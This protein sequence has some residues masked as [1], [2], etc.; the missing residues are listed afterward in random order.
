M[1]ISRDLL[2]GESDTGSNASGTRTRSRKRG[3]P[4]GANASPAK[5]TEL[6]SRQTRLAANSR[7][8][9]MEKVII[10]GERTSPRKRKGRGDVEKRVE[11]SVEEEEEGEGEREVD[12][13]GLDDDT[14]KEVKGHRIDSRGVT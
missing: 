7:K 12:P 14:F 5:K 1:N 13:D 2:E 11:S 10:P 3:A 8:R 4:F 9:E 6:V